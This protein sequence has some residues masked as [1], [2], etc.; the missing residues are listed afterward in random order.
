MNDVTF[1]R[2]RQAPLV[3][4]IMANYRGAAYLP[5]ALDAVLAQTVRDIE[6]IVSDDASA[7]DSAAIVR[8]FAARDPRVSL[9]EARENRGPAAARN[10]ALQAARGEWI[11]IVDSDDV[12]HP[13]RFDILLA[14]AGALK[15][16]AVADDLLFFSQADAGP[17]LLG[18]KATGQ[19]MPVSAE[20]FIRSN[21]S[22]TGLPPLGYLKP[23]FRRSRVA[24]LRYDESMRIAEDYD[25]LLRF[26][27][28]GG[29]LFVLPEPLYLYRR[30]S[31]S[32]SHRLSEAHM[33][34]LIANQEALVAT[35]GD[36]L[37]HAMRRELDV[38][39]TSL[40]NGLE[41][42]RLV[43]AM[44]GRQAA[45]TLGMLAAKPR[46]FAP[47]FRAASEHWQSRLA[48]PPRE[49]GLRSVVLHELH[50]TPDDTDAV[51]R[52]L[53]LEGDLE[54][55]QVPPYRP[56]GD[57]GATDQATRALWVG[58]AQ[59]GT[60]DRVRVA[61]RGL[62]GLHAMAF[63]P[64][65]VAASVIIDDRREVE[66]A[67]QYVC[68]TPTRLVLSEAAFDAVPAKAATQRLG[69]FHHIVEETVG[70]SRDLT[71]GFTGAIDAG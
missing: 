28:G 55:I 31:S 13:E 21:T 57:R 54:F 25:F 49:R 27:L 14:A 71:G 16:D 67:W 56:P 33:L 34:A 30:H 18:A 47:L 12:I 60:A 65:K 6:V 42:E 20:F 11:A 46:L 41:F 8:Q 2:A 70:P 53:G 22:G 50:T 63:L 9:I 38:R 17:T 52:E 4:V 58:L 68:G 66:R 29:R 32:I 3:S 61:A 48:R 24:A 64:E 15:A 36:L 10:K 23:I 37:S 39:M 40:R 69:G 5:A 26:L 45:R 19:P 43:A 35:N 59:A 7:D 51:Y 44:K 62:A 1:F